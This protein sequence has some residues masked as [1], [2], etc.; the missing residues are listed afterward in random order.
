MVFMEQNGSDPHAGMLTCCI[1]ISIYS[2]I[3]I[4]IFYITCRHL[5]LDLHLH[6][7]YQYQHLYLYIGSRAGHTGDVLHILVCGG[8]RVSDAWF[9]PHSLLP[10]REPLTYAKN[11]Q[12][13][14]LSAPVRTGWWVWC[15]TPHP[16]RVA[17]LFL[18]DV[19]LDCEYNKH[20]VTS[21]KTA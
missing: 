6:H 19:L 12:T 15:Q 14:T 5:R 10:S 21:I 2:Y 3:F 13:V 16:H 20:C 9:G 18:W 4:F 8:P 1:S 11:E 17:S 7:L